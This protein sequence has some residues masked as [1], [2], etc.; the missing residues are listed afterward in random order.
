MNSAPGAV[1]ALVDVPD[2][3][4][5][6]DAG[7]R[8]DALV[9]MV[10]GDL[11]Q[12]LVRFVAHERQGH[13]RSMDPVL[14]TGLHYVPEFRDGLGAEGRNGFR[15]RQANRTHRIV[16]TAD[17][18]GQPVDTQDRALAGEEVA[19]GGSEERC[20]VQERRPEDV[21]DLQARATLSAPD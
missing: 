2:G 10:L 1:L 3:L 6:C 17:R 5:N 9:G 7:E 4:S 13:D 21:V 14:C 20:V 8:A 12:H 16:E 11:R 15:G 18:G 19:V